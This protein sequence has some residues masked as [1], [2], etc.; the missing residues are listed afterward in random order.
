MKKRSSWRN[1]N[2]KTAPK[3]WP[4]RPFGHGLRADLVPLT[5]N[6]LDTLT[7]DLTGGDARLAQ[8]RLTLLNQLA[9]YFKGRM[10][11]SQFGGPSYCLCRPC[12]ED[13][14]EEARSPATSP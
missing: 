7:A 11:E 14:E 3:K 6:E 1:R 2:P 9:E 10:G 8:R 13:R 5:S 4:D 12:Q